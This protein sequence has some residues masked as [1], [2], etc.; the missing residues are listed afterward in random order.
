MAASPNA[1]KV[2]A[3]PGPVVVIATANLPVARD[4]PSAAYTQLCSCLTLTIS[5][6]TFDNAFQKPKLW[7]PGIPKAFF[8]PSFANKSKITAATVF[9]F[10]LSRRECPYVHFN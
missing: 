9:Q 4:K 8:T 1:P 10:C 5:G 3:A 7:T 6:R 2:L